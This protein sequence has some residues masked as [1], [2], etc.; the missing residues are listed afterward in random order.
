MFD[1]IM[2]FCNILEK[3][4]HDIHPLWQYIIITQ[5]SFIINDRRF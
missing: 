4:M 3:T 1:G 5:L 2:R